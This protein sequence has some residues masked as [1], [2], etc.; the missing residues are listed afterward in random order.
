MSTDSKERFS[1]RVAHYTKYRPGYPKAAIDFLYET[2][3]FTEAEAVADVGAGTGIFTAT[4]L[5]RGTFVYAVEP[6]PDM[7]RAAEAALAGTD[8]FVPVPGSAEE[9][10]LPAGSVD[11]VVCAQAFHWFDIARTKA[12]FAR[13]LRPDG[14]VA[15]IWNRRRPDVDAFNREY[16][17]LVRTYGNDYAE[18]NHN[19]LGPE[20]FEAF[21]RDG[22]YEMRTFE[23]L[24]TFDRE[25][26]RGRL[27]SSSY[28]PLPGE[29]GYEPLM[30]AMDDLFDRE[31]TDGTV[32]FQYATEIY[33]GRV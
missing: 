25:R 20:H 24:Q 27:L 12:E 13:I 16:E 29:A 30:S 7:R 26:L 32:A 28:C 8:G 3:G 6:N 14:V 19:N 15:L 33:Y 1:N 22:A 18:V 21:F 11:F 10:S 2:V 17:A 9:T 23:H 4:L 31:A 5:E